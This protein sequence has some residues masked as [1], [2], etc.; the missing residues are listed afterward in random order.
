MTTMPFVTLTLIVALGVGVAAQS[1]SVEIPPDLRAL[2]GRSKLSGP[3][4]TWCGAPLRAGEPR[5]FALALMSADGGRYVIL[6]AES[7]VRAL[8]RYRGQPDLSCYTRAEAE[9]LQRTIQQSDTIHGQIAPRF[10]T[11]VICGFVEDTTA[12]CWQYSPA[13]QM[14]VKIGGWTT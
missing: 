5:A 4:A 10:S 12:E 2:L 1:A 7:R 3:I 9:K 8:A 6:D 14:F 13:N 11:T